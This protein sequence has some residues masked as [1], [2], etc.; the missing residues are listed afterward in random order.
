MNNGMLWCKIWTNLYSWDTK[1]CH[2]YHK[3]FKYGFLFFVTCYLW[4]H[5]I[6]RSTI[7]TCMN[8][9]FVHGQL[10]ISCL[11]VEKIEFNINEEIGILKTINRMKVKKS[12]YNSW[13]IF[14]DAMDMVTLYLSS[15][16]RE[17]MM[18]PF[19]MSTWQ[20]LQCFENVPPRSHNVKCSKGSFYMSYP[21]VCSFLFD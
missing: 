13:S 10:V 15:L 6:M 8:L 21:P 20:H 4:I 3:R 1:F 12:N 14:H 2:C 7:N 16:Q 5:N 18:S 11:Q 19:I 9:Q 17:C